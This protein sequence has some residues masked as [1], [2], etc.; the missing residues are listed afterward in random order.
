M[1]LIA[2]T[3][4][5]KDGEIR[6]QIKQTLPHLEQVR[7]SLQDVLWNEITGGTDDTV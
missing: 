1:T 5:M 6:Q 4:T 7:L 3:K 2:A